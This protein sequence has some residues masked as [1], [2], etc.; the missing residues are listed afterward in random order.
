MTNFKREFG[1]CRVLSDAMDLTS[2]FHSSK[3]P[4]K[5][6]QADNFKK[7][8]L[9]TERRLTKENWVRITKF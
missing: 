5:K 9:G 3:L 8:K 4:Y 7:V 6:M 2:E 1:K